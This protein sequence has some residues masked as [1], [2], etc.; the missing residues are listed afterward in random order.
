MVRYISLFCVSIVLSVQTNAASVA[1]IDVTQCSGVLTS[2]LTDD[3]IFSCSG[4]LSLIGGSIDSSSKVI[5]SANGDIYL[6]N[7]QITAP[8]V[9]V[10]ASQGQVTVSN[11]VSFSTN[12]F[13]TA[14]PSLVNVST[15]GSLTIG[16]GGNIHQVT[17]GFTL[18]PITS[19]SSIHP[20]SYGTIITVAPIPLS[21]ASLFLLSSFF[22]L[23][24]LKLVQL[25]KY[26]FAA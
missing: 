24:G 11:N 14:N 1:L 7:I 9:D 21:S 10:T 25:R 18:L 6:D 22:A 12:V 23:A 4:N 15:G 16:T 13:F 17:D 19:G 2:S 20:G 8:H 26:A 3:A 5:I